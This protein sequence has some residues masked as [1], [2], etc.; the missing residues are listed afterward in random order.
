MY[1]SHISLRV[2]LLALLSLHITIICLF[3]CFQLLFVRFVKHSVLPLFANSVLIKC[4][5]SVEF[6]CCFLS[7]EFSCCFLSVE[8]S[9]CL[10]HFFPFAH[11]CLLVLSPPSLPIHVSLPLSS[12]FLHSLLFSLSCSYLSSISHSLALPILSTFPAPS[13][14]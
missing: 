6:S 11:T 3:F 14:W 8:F 12:S 2:F 4:F 7:V 10:L 1:N 9:C 5:S 13:P